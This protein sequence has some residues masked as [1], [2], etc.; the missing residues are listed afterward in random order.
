MHGNFAELVLLDVER[1][2]AP[3]HFHLEMSILF[4]LIWRND[5][6]KATLRGHAHVTRSIHR[7]KAATSTTLG[8]ILPILD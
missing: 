3:T 4:T 2:I 1:G 7:D 8:L 6:L 5:D